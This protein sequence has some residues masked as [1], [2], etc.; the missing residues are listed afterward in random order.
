MEKLK[1][2]DP[3]FD[4]SV[5]VA[6]LEPDTAVSDLRYKVT[7]RV[8][9][10]RVLTDQLKALAEE[11]KRVAPPE[12]VL[13]PL[14]PAKRSNWFYLL[15]FLN[16]LLLLGAASAWLIRRRGNAKGSGAPGSRGNE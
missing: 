6:V 15:V 10:E 5:F 12:T 7:Y 1:V 13:T 9:D 2:N 3:D 11:A 14:E 8:G 16:A 4:Q